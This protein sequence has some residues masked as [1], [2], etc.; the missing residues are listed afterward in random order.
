MAEALVVYLQTLLFLCCDSVQ[1]PIKELWRHFA[2]CQDA[3]DVMAQE[4]RERRLMKR[5]VSTHVQDVALR[6][7]TENKFV[8]VR[9]MIRTAVV[10]HC[11]DA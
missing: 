8:R 9:G 3:A 1:P 7:V 2:D 5:G 4:K 11:L 10:E 6:V